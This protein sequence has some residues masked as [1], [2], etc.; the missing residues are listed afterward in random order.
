MQ[1]VA[2]T[3]QATQLEEHFAAAVTLDSKYPSIGVHVKLI[4]C[5]KATAVSHVLQPLAF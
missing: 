1:L 5:L 4:N 2:V 3:A